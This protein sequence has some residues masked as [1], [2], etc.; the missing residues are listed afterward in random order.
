MSSVNIERQHYDL[1]EELVI[2]D[3]KLITIREHHTTTQPLDLRHTEVIQYKMHTA[4]RGHTLDLNL[5]IGLRHVEVGISNGDK[6]WSTMQTR[7][8]INRIG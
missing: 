1:D 5:N 7:H 2:H 3:Q 4:L 6:H 8:R